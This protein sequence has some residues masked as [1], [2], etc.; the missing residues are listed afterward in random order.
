MSWQIAWVASSGKERSFL[1]DDRDRADRVAKE[2]AGRVRMV[3][4][5]DVETHRVVY[6]ASKAARRNRMQVNQQAKPDPG[7]SDSLNQSLSFGTKNDLG[8]SS[9]RDSV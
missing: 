2:L 4:I 7:L 3:R 5:I 9:R 1:I 6:D 8:G